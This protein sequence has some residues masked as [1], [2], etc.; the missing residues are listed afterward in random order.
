ME[1]LTLSPAGSVLALDQVDEPHDPTR[2]ALPSVGVGGVDAPTVVVR[3]VPATESAEQLDPGRTIGQ[4]VD[5]RPIDTV[6]RLIVAHSRSSVRPAAGD[7]RSS[8]APHPLG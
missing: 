1:T 7:I 2:M 5:E 8:E 4:F 6:G 3:V